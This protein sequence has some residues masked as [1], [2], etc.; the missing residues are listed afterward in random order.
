MS[1]QSTSVHVGI[2]QP[3]QPLINNLPNTLIGVLTQAPQARPLQPITLDKM[4]TKR[5]EILQLLNQFQHH[6]D[7]ASSTLSAI[8]LQQLQALPIFPL[9]QQAFTYLQQA[10]VVLQAGEPKIDPKLRC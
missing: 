10:Q 9:F 5:M 6:I 8:Q 2:S 7:R 1:V 3:Q 4:M